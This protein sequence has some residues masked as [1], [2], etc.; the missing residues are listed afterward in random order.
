MTG[1]GGFGDLVRQQ[2][3]AAGLTQEELAEQAGL[4][5]RTVSD[6][7]RGRVARPHRHSVDLLRRALNLG[8]P[9]RAGRSAGSSASARATTP[10]TVPAA[11]SAGSAMVQPVVPRQLPPAVA[12]F[13]GRASEL[14]A[15]SQ[16][17]DQ[18]G[19][20]PPGAVVICAVDGMAGVGKTALA[21]LWAHQ[22]A[23]A[24]RRRAAIR[25]PARLR[26]RRRPGRARRGDP[27]VPGRPGRGARADPAQPG[28]PGRPVPQP[29]GRAED[30]DRAGQR[31]RRAAGPAAAA[32]RARA[33]W[34]WSPAAAS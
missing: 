2:R 12:Y 15:L 5:V 31:P 29:A 7:E 24:V 18:V 23:R 9:A 27:R 8:E 17:L 10:L 28:R 34:C 33:A 30:A 11:V 14:A 19:R 16:L 3:V 1:S 4:G 13:T 6:I 25:Q 32:R 26:P 22:V 20:G 21:V